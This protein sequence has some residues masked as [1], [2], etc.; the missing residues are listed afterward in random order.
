MADFTAI[1]LCSGSSSVALAQSL[2]PVYSWVLLTY[3]LQRRES[4]HSKNS[5][6]LIFQK[7]P[8]PSE[9]PDFTQVSDFMSF[10]M[11]FLCDCVKTHPGKK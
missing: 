2:N 7:M 9:G 6:M 4:G 8:R 1:N 11:C 3:E 10:S 5:T